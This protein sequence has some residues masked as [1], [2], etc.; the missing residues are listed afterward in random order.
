MRCPTCGA[1]T[2]ERLIV[3]VAGF[4]L[5][6]DGERFPVAPQQS[7]VMDLL[8]RNPEIHA[9]TIAQ[10]IGTSIEVVQV[11]ISALREIIAHTRL[12]IQT[13]KG[14]GRAYQLVWVG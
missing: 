13:P 10:I 3:N 11:Q 5:L 4:S 14:W 1:P 6:I 9:A 7:R 8:D 12:S 2:T